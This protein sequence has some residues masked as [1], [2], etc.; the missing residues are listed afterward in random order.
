MKHLVGKAATKK[1]DFMGTKLEVSKL[2]VSQV[3]SIQEQTKALGEDG[4]QTAILRM[5]LDFAVE[6]AKDLSDE[7]FRGFPIEDLSNL[8]NEVMKFSGLG[9]D[10]K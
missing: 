9:N 3:M 7:E 8:S 4:D 10:K 1:I 5:V 6:G 2:T